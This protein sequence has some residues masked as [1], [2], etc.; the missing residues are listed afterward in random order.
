MEIRPMTSRTRP[1]RAA[2]VVPWLLLLMTLSACSA[3]SGVATIDDADDPSASP[4][5][6]AAAEDPEEAMFAFAECMREQ[7]IDMPDPVI[8]RFD[9]SGAD[10]GPVVNENSAPGDGPAF[11]PLSEEYGT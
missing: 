5:S 8:R 11:D 3:A 1:R 9:A 2:L 4:S 10:G 7:G 6:S